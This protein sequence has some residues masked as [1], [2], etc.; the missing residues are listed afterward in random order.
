MTTK[1]KTEIYSVEIERHPQTG[2]VIRELWR[3]AA[4]K[5][6][7]PNDQPAEIKYSKVTGKPTL[8]VWLRNGLPHRDGDR[9][10]LVRY[11]EISGNLTAEGY[12]K[13]GAPHRELNRPSGISVTSDGTVYQRMFHVAGQLHRTDGPAQEFFDRKTGEPTAAH[14]WLNDEPVDP[15]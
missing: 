11:D 9:P 8:M 7:R 5:I 2:Q 1:N 13:N 15:F 14:Y 3:N 6:D 10:S 4:G 12:C